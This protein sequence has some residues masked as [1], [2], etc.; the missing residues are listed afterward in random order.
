MKTNQLFNFSRNIFFYFFLFNSFIINGQ[1]DNKSKIVSGQIIKIE[2]DGNL[3]ETFIIQV[4]NS[5]GTLNDLQ[6][7]IKS[8]SQKATLI[9]TGTILVLKPKTTIE[10]R[11]SN[12]NE[13]QIVADKKEKIVE[14][15][16]SSYRELYRSMD[17]DDSGNLISRVFKPLVGDVKTAN[18]DNTFNGA[19]DGTEW[20]VTFDG[21]NVNYKI[22][23]GKVLI[24]GRT[25]IEMR[26]NLLKLE[27]N[28]NRILYVTETLGRFKVKDST[29]KFNP[30]S[31]VKKPLTSEEAINKF[32]KTELKNQKHFLKSSG[33]HSKLGYKLLSQG[34][35]KEGVSEYNKAIEMGEMDMDRFIQASLILT[36][37]THELSTK[38]SMSNSGLQSPQ[39]N[40]NKQTWL[41]ASLHFIKENDSISKSKHDLF[42]NEGNL[43]I[44]KAYGYEQVLYKEYLAWAYTVKLKLNG[45]LEN[46]DQNPLVLMKSVE[47]IKES[48]KT[49]K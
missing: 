27:G 8:D 4:A 44:A 1:T 26:D 21:V 6:I 34:Q 30:D 15:L 7:N 37:A 28:N 24:S 17:D 18:V 9:S 40:N 39:I 14:Y 5:N 43:K 45:C 32:F 49:Y 31:L 19:A 20:K 48:L 41:E 36:E 46:Q 22:L 35:F 29:V 12:G 47:K 38:E 16:V 13:L 33:Y 10:I 2:K 42:K 25:K 3:K 23:E 11:S